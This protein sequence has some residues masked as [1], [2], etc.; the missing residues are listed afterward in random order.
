MIPLIGI[1][2][3]TVNGELLLKK[4]VQESENIL[5]RPRWYSGI[6]CIAMINTPVATGACRNVVVANV[7]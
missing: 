2:K 4:C 7:L 1:L 3:V 6:V 5:E